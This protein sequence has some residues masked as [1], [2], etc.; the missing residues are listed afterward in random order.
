MS[1]ITASPPREYSLDQLDRMASGKH[2]E[3]IDGYLEE[4]TVSGLSSY[5]AGVLIELLNAHCRPSRLAYVFPSD[6]GYVCFGS[7]KRL[8]RPDVSCVLTERLT[9]EQLQIGYATIPPDLA[10]EVISP[11]DLAYKIAEKVD[12]YLKAGVRLIWVIEPVRQTVHLYRL[13][14]SIAFLRAGDEL[15]GEGVLPGFHCRVAD[16]FGVELPSTSPTTPS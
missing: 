5:V 7:K 6:Y 11:T 8:R 2:Y 13:D 14:G 9:L 3:L 10:V 1:T 15:S 12:E 4:R 16:L